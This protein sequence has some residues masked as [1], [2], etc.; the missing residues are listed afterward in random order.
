MPPDAYVQEGMNGSRIPYAGPDHNHGCGDHRFV[1]PLI[2]FKLLRI[3]Y[4]G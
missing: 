4:I 2:F 3:S 1:L